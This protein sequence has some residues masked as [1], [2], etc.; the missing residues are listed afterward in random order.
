MAKAR[1]STAVGARILALAIVAA[2]LGAA[3]SCSDPVHDSEVA[4]LGGETDIPQ[5]EYHR[6]GQPCGV[7]HGQE[8]PAYARFVVV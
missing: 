3:A 1:S 2:A 4:A 8:G 6:A 5:G 7:C